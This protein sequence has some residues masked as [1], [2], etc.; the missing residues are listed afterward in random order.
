MLYDDAEALS[1]VVTD[2]LKALLISDVWLDCEA[3]V[4]TVLGS[5]IGEEMVL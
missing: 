5:N 3:E 4:W 2:K 1:T